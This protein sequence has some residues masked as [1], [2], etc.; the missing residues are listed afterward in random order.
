MAT[1]PGRVDMLRQCLTHIRPQVDACRV[2][3]NG[4]EEAPSFLQDFDCEWVLDPVNRG[5]EKK[6]HWTQDWKGLYFSVDDDILY[7]PNYVE[8][9]RNAVFKH[10]L[11]AIVGLLGRRFVGRAVDFRGCEIRLGHR[12][13]LRRPMWVN[14]LGTGTTAFHTRLNVPSV[15][16]I[17]N[18][19]DAQLAVWA[20]KQRVPMLCLERPSGWLGDLRG[21][22]KATDG[23]FASDMANDFSLRNSIYQSHEPW[24][25]YKR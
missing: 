14:M 20:Q 16:P 19:L 21:G 6:F 9:M 15:W 8:R 23:V 1:M 3:L 25:V 11:R 17:Q 24:I 22:Y 13:G 4:F 5:A 18:S 12:Y 10:N 7:P 2:Y